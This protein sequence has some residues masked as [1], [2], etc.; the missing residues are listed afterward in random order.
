[1]A[2]YM[3]TDMPFYGVTSN[4]RKLISRQLAAEFPS[5]SRADYET[6]V[7]VLWLGKHREDKYVA[8]AYARS[9]PRYVTLSS[10]PIYRSM[11]VQ[12]A[13][14]DFVDEIA[15]LRV[16]AVALGKVIDEPQHEHKSGCFIAVHR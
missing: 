9:F 11:I 7:R 1:M 6:A 15:D 4:G 3:K 13:W 2:A 8:I 14:W 16:I 12:G 5:Q 10:I